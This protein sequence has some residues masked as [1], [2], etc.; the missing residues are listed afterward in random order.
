MR[1]ISQALLVL[2]ACLQASAT[3]LSKDLLLPHTTLP[4]VTFRIHDHSSI[5][6]S[7]AS[8]ALRWWLCLNYM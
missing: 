3:R 2:T 4:E 7:S 6:C 8:S 5:A 1:L